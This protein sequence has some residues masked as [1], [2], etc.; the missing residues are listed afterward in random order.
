MHSKNIYYFSLVLAPLL[1][2]VVDSYFLATG[3]AE[4]ECSL[5]GNWNSRDSNI[6]FLAN[7][8]VYGRVGAFQIFD[9]FCDFS[10]T[11]SVSSQNGYFDWDVSLRNCS[12]AG[13]EEEIVNTL[14][15]TFNGPEYT[16]ASAYLDFSS[17][18][19]AAFQDECST[20]QF[21][22]FT[23]YDMQTGLSVWSLIDREVVHSPPAPSRGGPVQCTLRGTEVSTFPKLGLHA[24]GW[25]NNNKIYDGYGIYFNISYHP[26]GTYV[27]KVTKVNTTSGRIECSVAWT[28]KYFYDQDRQEAYPYV[29]LYSYKTTVSRQ[30]G[31]PPKGSACAAF[32]LDPASCEYLAAGSPSSTCFIEWNYFRPGHTCQMFRL[33]DIDPYI[34]MGPDFQV[35]RR[36]PLR[37]ED[38]DL[39]AVPSLGSS[40]GF[41]SL[42]FLVVSFLL[43]LY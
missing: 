20:L 24:N 17:G 25:L 34:Q 37:L 40:I 33:F 43:S 22:S 29:T 8:T 30:I 31:K 7:G 2:A 36:V 39:Q 10:G 18:C 19:F 41:S 42:L 23:G 1:F 28:G 3:P 5:T 16:S 32:S 21:T 6:T 27:S 13:T 4:L 35:L 14:F 15:C 11:Y 9:Y 26:G 38:S 12:F